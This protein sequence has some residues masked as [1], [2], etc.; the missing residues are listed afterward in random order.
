MTP[1]VSIIIPT[2]NR[3]ELLRET[4][5][6]AVGQTYPHWEAIIV[7]DGSDDGTEEMVREVAST[8]TR[9]RFVRRARNPRGASTC[10]NIGVSAASGEYVVFLDS[11]DLLAPR[12]LERRVEV[13]QQHPQV[14]F[15][16]FLTQLF[17][18]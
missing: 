11:D 12:C 2:K 17:H 14:D 5:A 6:S 13:M 15:A 7:D 9:V 10:R 1:L 16:V 4:I 3:C 8:D 18:H